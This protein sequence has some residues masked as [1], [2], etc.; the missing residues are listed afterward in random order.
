MQKPR[1]SSYECQ[2]QSF[3][4]TEEYPFVQKKHLRDRASAIGR[5]AV[6]AIE[7]NRLQQPITSSATLQKDLLNSLF[8]CFGL[9]TGCSQYL[10]ENSTLIIPETLKCSSDSLMHKPRP[11]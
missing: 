11:I 6:Y 1:S 10:C 7:H 3:A 4:E 5:Y 2:S 8:H 9:H